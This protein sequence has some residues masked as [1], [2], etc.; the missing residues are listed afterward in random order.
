MWHHI[1]LPGL[2]V[3]KDLEV[4]RKSVL[5]RNIISPRMLLD[6]VLKVCVASCAGPCVWVRHVDV[7][8]GWGWG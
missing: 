8:Q 6:E 2:Q 7:A 3:R 4:M 5:L 1:P